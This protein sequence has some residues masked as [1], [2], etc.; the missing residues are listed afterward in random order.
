MF[1]IQAELMLAFVQAQLG[2]NAYVFNLRHFFFPQN[3]EFIRRNKT[4]HNIFSQF[5]SVQFSVQYWT[6]HDFI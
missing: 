2:W 5:I 1:K 6:L 4:L 3:R